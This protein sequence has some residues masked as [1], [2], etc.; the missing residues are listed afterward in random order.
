MSGPDAVIWH[1]LEC[2]RYAED[3][4][5]WRELADRHGDPVL[6]VG[7]GTGR[8]ALDLARRGHTVTALDSDAVL[9][10][11][12]DRRAA[13]LDVTTV[14]ADARTVALEATFPLCL[15][16]M[17]T[18]QLLGGADG[19]L[20]FLRRARDHLRP[21]GRLAIALADELEMFEVADGGPGPLPDVCELEGT[22]YSSR[23]TAVRERPGGFTLER[24]R[25][26][27]T[28]AGELAVASDAIDLDRLDPDALEDEG[29]AAGLTP[30]GRAVIQPT[31]EHVGSVVVLLGG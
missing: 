23:P 28:P 26:T 18:I 8:T 2:G 19:R 16:P 27:V 31:A 24:R 7:A 29:R 15:V 22:V 21:G 20:R 13:G 4:P 30:A 14:V 12:L 17:Q 10:A 11:E 5:L 9:L 25:E 3:L 6:D 1:D